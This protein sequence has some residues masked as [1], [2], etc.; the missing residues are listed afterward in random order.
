VSSG[1]R[2]ARAWPIPA[3]SKVVGGPGHCDRGGGVISD[4]IK[5]GHDARCVGFF[6]GTGKKSFF[7]NRARTEFRARPSETIG[8][9]STR[10]WCAV[11][12]FPSV[13]AGRERVDF[14][15]AILERTRFRVGLNLAR[16]GAGGDC[17]G[18][19]PKTGWEG[20][21]PKRSVCPK[22]QGS[23]KRGGGPGISARPV[24]RRSTNWN[25]PRGGPRRQQA[26]WRGIFTRLG[27]GFQPLPTNLGLGSFF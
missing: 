13:R 15:W 5:K 19:G 26:H 6:R 3:P 25:S 16:P 27:Q 18:D 14:P 8:E 24:M 4:L 11:K 22:A 12:T 10:R 2:R 21:F 20:P 1:G 23:G 17:G 9:F 7:T